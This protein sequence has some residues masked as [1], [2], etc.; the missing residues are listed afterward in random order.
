MV[1]GGVGGSEKGRRDTGSGSE[2]SEEVR[3]REGE[4]GVG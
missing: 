3:R 1:D 2:R 4:W